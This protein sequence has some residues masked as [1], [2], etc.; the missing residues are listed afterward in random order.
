[1]KMLTLDFLQNLYNP[2]Y[3]VGFLFLFFWFN[4]YQNILIGKGI[5]LE[6]FSTTFIG[7][8]FF[9]LFIEGATYIFLETRLNR[10]QRR[11][12]FKYLGII[13]LPLV[14]L[15]LLST[16]FIFQIKM[17]NILIESSFVLLLFLSIFKITNSLRYTFLIS[18]T[19]IFFVSIFLALPINNL[20]LSLVLSFFII[21]LLVKH[22][23][24]DPSIYDNHREISKAL[25]KQIKIRKARKEIMIDGGIFLHEGEIFVKTNREFVDKLNKQVKYKNL[26][27]LDVLK[28]DL[29]KLNEERI[30]KTLR[31]KLS[32]YDSKEK[33]EL[34]KKASKLVK[35]LVSK[36]DSKLSL[37]PSIFSL[38]L[39][40]K[41]AMRRISK[42]TIDSYES[43][44]QHKL[45][46]KFLWISD[47]ELDIIG[48]L[49]KLD[50]YRIKIVVGL[51]KDI[52]SEE[53]VNL[54]KRLIK[55]Y[56]KNEKKY[57]Y[58]LI[59]SNRLNEAE[60]I[61]KKH[62][63]VLGGYKKVSLIF[64]NNKKYVKGLSKLIS[65]Y[66]K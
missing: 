38:L 62:P 13:T 31:D 17:D 29:L 57:S 34:I 33:E 43:L 65:K 60:K 46:S 10:T 35:P 42:R 30:K 22:S 8:I 12:I 51:L 3:R 4:L 18:W 58:S 44:P 39:F 48:D 55:D 11:F 20:V 64:E 37:V 49:E 19:T 25:S 63:V 15:T 47:L 5:N 2:V 40:N 7:Y 53:L 66:N 27:K 32:K 28:E 24:L 56:F 1:M 52:P 21:E 14:I 61:Y 6:L 26:K 23:E 45:D 50:L 54:L 41:K 9:I 36:N 16:F 59:V